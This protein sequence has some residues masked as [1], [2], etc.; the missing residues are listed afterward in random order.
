[1]R[2]CFTG[3]GRA[4]TG[5]WALHAPTVGLLLHKTDSD[6]QKLPELAYF[7]SFTPDIS[8]TVSGILVA[9]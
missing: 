1:M 8:G 4:P 7:L 6:P 2:T 9:F 5:T 3:I